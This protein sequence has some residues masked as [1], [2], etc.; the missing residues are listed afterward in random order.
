MATDWRWC[1]TP[2]RLRVQLPTFTTGFVLP[3]IKI[4]YYQHL[5]VSF[6]ELLSLRL[7]EHVALVVGCI[8]NNWLN[9]WKKDAC[10]LFTGISPPL[11]ILDLAH[12]LFT[13]AYDHIC[14]FDKVTGI[15]AIKSAFSSLSGQPEIRTSFIIFPFFQKVFSVFFTMVIKWSSG[16]EYG[17]QLRN[18]PV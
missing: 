2:K 17:R 10:K 13:L 16:G 8:N 3:S 14:T 9:L 5:L 11:C 4:V 15:L 12:G 6:E 1:W 7:S 18:P